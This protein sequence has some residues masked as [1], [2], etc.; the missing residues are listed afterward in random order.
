MT[1][2]KRCH[3]G[4]VNFLKSEVVENVGHGLQSDELASADISLFLMGN[5]YN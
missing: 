4:K 5:D 1:K 2:K 3:P